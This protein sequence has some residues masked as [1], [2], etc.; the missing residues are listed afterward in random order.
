MSATKLLLFGGGRQSEPFKS[1]WTAKL[2]DLEARLTVRIPTRRRN[3]FPG[4]RWDPVWPSVLQRAAR[5]LAIDTV[6]INGGMFVS[7][8]ADAKRVKEHAQ[9]LW[10][11]LAVR[12]R[13]ASEPVEF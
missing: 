11:E 1:E 7:T 3:P 12:L 8:E 9:T 5:E 2:R 10:E 4:R 13:S 6:Q